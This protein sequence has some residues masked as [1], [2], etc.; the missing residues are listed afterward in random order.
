MYSIE[1]PNNKIK[2]ILTQNKACHFR[3]I[4][5][6]F[7][8]T[9]KQWMVFTLIIRF[10]SIVFDKFIH[11]VIIV[12]AYT[13]RILKITVINVSVKLSILIQNID[14]MIN[15]IWCQDMF[16]T[17]CCDTTWPKCFLHGYW[18]MTMHLHLNSLSS[19]TTNT[20]AAS[21]STTE[22]SWLLFSAMY[23]ILAFSEFRGLT[24]LLYWIVFISVDPE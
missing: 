13:P 5:F 15:V 14:T 3:L 22:T 11:I 7:Y 18:G 23:L 20:A 6:K 19:F 9:F 4:N 17:V 2:D 1:N 24:S 21:K 8:I 12:Y 16:L 10:S